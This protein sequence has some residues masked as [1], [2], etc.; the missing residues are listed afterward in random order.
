MYI[1]EVDPTEIVATWVTMDKCA[2]PT[3]EY[4]DVTSGKFLDLNST[5]YSK[6]FQDG[7]SEKRTMQIHRVVL[8]SL[9]P[10]NT[11]RK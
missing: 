5:G 9:T 4:N 11:Y 2:T 8:K 7:G 10:G 3:V 6:I 1:I